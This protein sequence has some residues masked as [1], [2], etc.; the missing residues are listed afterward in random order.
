MG[1]AE[2]VKEMDGKIPRPKANAIHVA[3]VTE[4]N[5]SSAPVRMLI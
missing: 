3:S 1:N 4:S 5:F 2:F